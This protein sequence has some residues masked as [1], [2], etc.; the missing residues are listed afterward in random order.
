MIKLIPL[1]IDKGA[2]LNSVGN[3]AGQTPL[4]YACSQKQIDMLKLLI[5]KGA[6]VNAQTEYG[7]TALMHVARWAGHAI[8]MELLIQHGAKVNLKDKRGSTALD[9]AK[10]NSKY[11]EENIAL[12]TKYGATSNNSKIHCSNCSSH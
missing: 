12:L 4:M 5:S 8:A 3:S 1:L 2:D 9:I 6:Q 10:S 7:E 11:N